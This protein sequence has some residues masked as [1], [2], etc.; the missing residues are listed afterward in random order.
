MCIRDRVYLANLRHARQLSA[1]VTENGYDAVVSSHLFPMET[2]T[3]LRRHESFPVPVSYTHLDVYKRQEELRL[4]GDVPAVAADGELAA[5]FKPAVA[6]ADS[7]LLYTSVLR[8]GRV[9][10]NKVTAKIQI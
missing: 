6:G 1:F 8:Q 10:L 2:L 5:L 7:C 3:F 4:E 9:L